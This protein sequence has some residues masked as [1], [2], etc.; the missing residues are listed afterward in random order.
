MWT[1]LPLLS[2]RKVHSANYNYINKGA[3]TDDDSQCE[4]PFVRCWQVRSQPC[5]RCRE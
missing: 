5:G 3:T 1:S 4:P 2:N